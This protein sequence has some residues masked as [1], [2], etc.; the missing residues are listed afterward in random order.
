[1]SS[2]QEDLAPLISPSSVALVG[3]SPKQASVGYVILENL[4]D[5]FRGT[6]YFV[7]PKYDEVEIKGSNS[8]STNRYR[9]S[10]GPWTSSS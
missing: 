8:S 6:A 1:M 5:R 7:N 10:Q 2:S 4:I 9:R 3:A